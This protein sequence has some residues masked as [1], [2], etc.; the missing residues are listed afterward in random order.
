M[1]LE[2][3]ACRDPHSRA[4]IRAV[5]SG[6]DLE[7][8]LK[9]DSPRLQDS[10]HSAYTDA[11][12]G[13]RSSPDVTSVPAAPV[14]APSLSLLSTLSSDLLL[15]SRAA[16]R[17][18]LAQL[19]GCPQV[20]CSGAALP[21]LQQSIVEPGALYAAHCHALKKSTCGRPAL[22]CSTQSL[23]GQGFASVM[24]WKQ[25]T[26]PH[27]NSKIRKNDGAPAWLRPGRDSRRTGPPRIK[28]KNDSSAQITNAPA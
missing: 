26:A 23:C 2:T 25:G 14:D 27:K 17:R 13:G 9:R 20:Y 1:T 10:W 22:K 7:A 5:C 16:L 18:W 24:S 15:P 12:D 21:A 28:L 19:E 8:C 11:S 3:A 4:L 6:Y